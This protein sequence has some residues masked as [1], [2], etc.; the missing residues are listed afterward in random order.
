MQVHDDIN[1]ANIQCVEADMD[2]SD[3]L[4]TSDASDFT[5]TSGADGVYFRGRRFGYQYN[6][7]YRMNPHE[8]RR[9]KIRR[10]HVSEELEE[11]LFWK[12]IQI[13]AD[14]SII[15]DG[16][17][18]YLLEGRFQDRVTKIDYFGVF[19]IGVPTAQL[20]DDGGA[21]ALNM[22]QLGWWGEGVYCVTVLQRKWRNR[23]WRL[24]VQPRLIQLAKD[25]LKP[26]CK[27]SRSLSHTFK[28]R[29]QLPAKQQNSMD[30]RRGSGVLVIDSNGVVR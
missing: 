8:R 25:M 21:L 7:G 27:T 24:C 19:R 10:R 26:I 29:Q 14:G 5:M 16:D 3:T 12:N 4:D 9:F 11:M 30:A 23:R 1:T 20:W 28:H 2:G 22:V 17:D 13:G 6:A 15:E 18:V